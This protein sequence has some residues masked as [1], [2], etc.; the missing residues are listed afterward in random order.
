MKEKAG[1]KTPHVTFR[2]RPEDLALL[3]ALDQQLGI[4][5]TGVFRLALRRLAAAEG[6]TIQRTVT[7]GDEAGHNK[8]AA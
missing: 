4:G 8:A 3:R 2:V 6:I 5:Q 7:E 1:D